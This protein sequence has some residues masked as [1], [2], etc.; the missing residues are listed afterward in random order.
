MW[1]SAY[2]AWQRLLISDH[3]VLWGNLSRL[4]NLL[5][6]MNISLFFLT[7]LVE[8][9]YFYTFTSLISLG[10]V[11]LSAILAIF[12]IR[13][14]WYYCCCLVFELIGLYYLVSSIVYWVRFGSG[15]LAEK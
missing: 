2:T 4:N 14:L 1:K 15:Q 12:L 6:I 9:G 3:V 11:S 7:G 8:R 10:V 5:I 13:K